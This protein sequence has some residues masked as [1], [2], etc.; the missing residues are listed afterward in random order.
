MQNT[1]SLQMIKEQ[2]KIKTV[3]LR[4][5]T[6]ENG[7]A[8]KKVRDLIDFNKEE[9]KKLK[10]E[11]KKA[12]EEA[13]AQKN[14]AAAARLAKH[15]GVEAGKKEREEEEAELTKELE[16]KLNK[17][18]AGKL[19]ELQKRTETL[20]TRV[21]EEKKS[22]KKFQR[23]RDILMKE[24]KRLRED[25]GTVDN[26]KKKVETL[27]VELNK[28]K[29]TS[30]SSG[31]VTE[32][33]VKEKDL[34]IKKYE[35]ML[36]GGLDAGEDG[37]LPSEIIQELK[38]EVDDLEKERRTMIVELEM[39]KEDNAEMDMK[40]TLLE[41][42]KGRGGKGGEEGGFRPIESRAAQTAE[43]SA[44][45]ENFLI[46][47]SDMVTLLLVIFVLMYTVSKLDENRFAEAL[48][49]FQ[50]KRMRIESVNVRLS[51][52][53]LKML[54]R[55]REL[56][57]D[58]VDAESLVRSDTRTI[59]HRLPTSD[60]FAPGEAFFSEG[61]EDLIISTIQEDMKEGVKQLLVDGHTDNV[62]MKSAKFP[63]NWELSAARAS[64][65]ARFIIEKMR[66]PP[67]RMVVTGYGEFRPLL[68]N[69]NDDNRAANRRVEIKI[70]KALEVA[71]K[72]AQKAGKDSGGPLGGKMIPKSQTSP[73]A[74]EASK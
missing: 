36:Y 56:V 60:L 57:K 52:D 18:V 62:A 44:G 22:N 33:I 13:E 50:T 7:K 4:K 48:S 38:E 55:V 68:E 71:E 54:Q 21:E 5:A 23:E 65:V 16:E 29:K 20:R 53:G 11:V 10:E 72:E 45:L 47:Y 9:T 1:E 59:L 46:T 24:L 58:N 26:L 17:K 61:A 15:A 40:I 37:M 39:L 66:F 74:P 64:K 43:F 12:Q 3:E 32:D 2:L 67:E 28:A 31:V 6:E 63:S 42:E 49:S 30:M 14:E 51:K 41:D 25:T 35:D 34:L 73:D 27:K 69:T 70:L 8:A 19:E